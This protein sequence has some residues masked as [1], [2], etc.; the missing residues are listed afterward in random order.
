MSREQR[1]RDNWAL[2]AARQEALR[3][4]KPLAVVFCLVPDFPG[5]SLRHYMFLLRGLRE[6]SLTLA[7]L[8]ISF[9]LLRGEPGRILPRFL[10]DCNATLLVADFNPLRI[11]RRWRETVASAITIPFHE[12]DAH[13][14]VP[15]WLASAKKE[16]AA[17]TFRP[18]LNRML[19]AFLT[20]FPEIQPHPYGARQ[21]SPVSL[22]VDGM[23]RTIADQSVPEVS[24]CTPGEKE[25]LRAL[26]DFI[27]NG[28]ARYPAVRNNP[29]LDGQSSLSPYLHFGQLAPQRAALE[30]QR[31]AAPA[32]ARS[33]FLEE[34]IVRRELADNF[35]LYE[36]RYDR[37]D[38]FH[39]WAQK[40]IDA[41]RRD[42]RAH[43]YSMEE[44]DRGRTH[45]PLWNAC[46]TD[47]RNR[48]KLH[49]YLR[50]YWAKKILEWS[51]GPEEAL[52][53][54][55]LLN[56]RYSLDGRDP[57]GYAGIAWSI[58]GVHDRAWAERPVYGKIRYMSQ[59]G[60]RRKFD[61]PPTSSG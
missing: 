29:C 50:M 48:G 7:G 42:P 41:H 16:F 13:N 52:Q 10:A 44:F 33:A 59:E 36:P 15:A 22:D 3:L 12:V 6:L 31:S 27:G 5:A 28:L 17:H 1:V 24:W 14:I 40:T 21:S 38:G 32:E 54:A 35:C 55:I 4:R 2:L 20:E 8:H 23:A 57:N 47:L 30:V 43:L 19:D 45:D 26:H 53:T 37:F 58:G 46:Q 34:L 25:G 61:V 56:D 39:D 11:K 18:R 49:G 51:A 60:C 9:H